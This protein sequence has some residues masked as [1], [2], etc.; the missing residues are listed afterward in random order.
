MQKE[1][2]TLPVQIKKALQISEDIEIDSGSLSNIVI[3]GMG[4]SGI[5][6]D[7]FKNLYS[8]PIPIYV[9][10]ND[11]LPAIAGD[12][13]L[14]I[15]ISYSGD[16]EETLSTLK[17]AIKKNIVT[18]VISS[19]GK[20]IDMCDKYEIPLCKIPGEMEPRSAVGYLTFSL[21]GI[22]E[23]SNI[24]SGV[25]KSA[26]NLI[27]MLEDPDMCFQEAAEQL[28]KKMKGKIPVIFSPHEYS[29]LSYR[30]KTQIN[31]NSKQFAYANVY[32]EIFHNELEGFECSGNSAYVVFLKD[33]DAKNQYSKQLDF[34]KKTLAKKDIPFSEI[35]MIGD[36][37]IEKMFTSIHLGDWISYYLGIKNG[38]DIK[39]IKKVN[40]IE[41]M[42]R[43]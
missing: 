34:L 20:I 11:Q 5:A 13:T 7:I 18:L 33:P 38:V 22:M 19:G 12:N 1:I 37:N 6:G 42:K 39:D 36:S 17:E 29:S 43:S 30:W 41:G 4:G 9:N 40:L 15:S 26:R 8:G 2:K 35:E 23:N 14:L 32:P 21:L 28:A 25:S 10:K 31:E 24:L 27:A 16:T 3:D